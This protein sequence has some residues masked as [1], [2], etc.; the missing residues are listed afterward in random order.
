MLLLN[1]IPKA[2]ANSFPK[3]WQQS[4]VRLSTLAANCTIIAATFAVLSTPSYAQNV[5]TIAGNNGLSGFAGDGGSATAPAARLLFPLAVLARAD[6]SVLIAEQ[7]GNRVRKVDVGGVIT[8][9][10]GTG[11]NSFTGDSGPATAAQINGPG[12]LLE[13]AAGNIYIGSRGAIRKVT[14]AGI[15]ST[16]VGN[17]TQANTGDGG[18]A[19]AAQVFTVWGMRFDSAGN[20]FFSDFGAHVVRKIDTAGMITKIA[21]TG[22]A[23]ASGGDNLPALTAPLNLP[24]GIVI[25]A[26]GSLIVAVGFQYRVRKIIPGGNITTIAGTGANSSTGDNG[27]ATAATLNIPWGLVTDGNGGYF[28]SEFSGNRVRNIAGSGTITTV[29]GDGTA[30]NTG[31]GGLATA[32]TINVPNGLGRD[33]AGNL[34]ITSD[35]HVVRKIIAPPPPILGPSVFNAYVNTT[36]AALG[37]ITPAGEQTVPFGGTVMMT[38]TPNP[39]HVH[40]VSS[41]CIYTQTNQPVAF[42]PIGTGINTYAVTVNGPC[43]MEATFTPLIPKASVAIEATANALFMMTER[44]QIY[45]APTAGAQTMSTLG[46]SVTFKAWLTDIAGVPYASATNV[47]TFKANGAAI[48]GCSNVPLT[49]RGSNVLHIRE[50]N[51]VTSFAVAGNTVITSEFGGDTYNFP[52][53]SGGLN[54]SVSAAP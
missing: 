13:D 21:G 45:V 22:V 31:D 23:A 5:T 34:F 24:L 32:A 30:T 2:F 1:R 20:L 36:T 43:Q 42:V 12:A 15:I 41:N 17:G 40:R 50:A 7:A 10:A 19:T 28:V 26:D 47:I 48:A 16:I 46:Q 33:N 8:T 51:C 37:T 27:P 52:A 6:G 3:T 38:V 25:A 14:P 44:S 29:I 54:H 53:V 35:G 18:L 39:R 9:F 4:L 49:L 11:G